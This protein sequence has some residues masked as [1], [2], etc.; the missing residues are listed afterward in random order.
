MIFLIIDGA[1]NESVS[2]NSELLTLPRGGLENRAGWF[3][4]LALILFRL[5]LGD[6]FSIMSL[7]KISLASRRVACK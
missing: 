3:F 6:A 7:A 4:A 1:L 5:F 2:S